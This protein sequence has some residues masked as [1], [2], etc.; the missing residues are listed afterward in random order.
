MCSHIATLQIRL[1]HNVIFKERQ[2]WA[3]K[4]VSL[5]V[6]F[7]SFW[8]HSNYG[9]VEQLWNN[10]NFWPFNCER[11]CSLSTGRLLGLIAAI[12]LNMESSIEIVRDMLLHC[13]RDRQ[14]R[15]ERIATQQGAVIRLHDYLH[16]Q[17]RQ[18]NAAAA[19]AE[20]RNYAI[21]MPEE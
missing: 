8:I 14:H 19:D 12:L 15:L 6:G 18:V 17:R 1:L 21:F 3:A 11:T 16:S 4:F 13:K 7:E 2:K 10:L 9:Q 20:L 5:I